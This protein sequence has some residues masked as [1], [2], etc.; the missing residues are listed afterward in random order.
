M[1]LTLRHKLLAAF[2]G[3]SA[4][5]LIVGGVGTFGAPTMGGVFTHYRDQSVVIDRMQAEQASGS[6][7]S[8]ASAAE[9]LTA[10]IGEIDHTTQALASAVEEQTAATGEISSNAQQA[11][12]GARSVTEDVTG[13]QSAVS[14]TSTVSEDGEYGGGGAQDQFSAIAR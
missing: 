10:S 12:E 14:Q 11:A 1:T 13:I 8:V 5:V 4:L 2:T 3:L 9:E 6:V 7:E